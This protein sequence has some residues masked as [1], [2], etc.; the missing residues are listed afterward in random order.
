MTLVEFFKRKFKRKIT[1][2]F[3]NSTV[4]ITK[5]QLDKFNDLSLFFVF[6]SGKVLPLHSEYQNSLEK[7][8]THGQYMYKDQLEKLISNNSVS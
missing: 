5:E 4:P 1:Y 3:I 2:T 6:K 8:L 7:Y